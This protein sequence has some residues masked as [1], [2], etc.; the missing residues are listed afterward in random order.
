MEKVELLL[1]YHIL[2]EF[3]LVVLETNFKVDLC[4]FSRK[5]SITIL[6]FL[7]IK[8]QPPPLHLRK[9]QDSIL[10]TIH[11][12][13]NLKLAILDSFPI[14]ISSKRRDVQ[15]IRKLPLNFNESMLSYN[16]LITDHTDIAKTLFSEM[17]Y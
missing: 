17:S 5:Q 15:D 4:W 14:G 16:D 7:K 3:F 12:L 8:E 13:P 11:F 9:L 2:S 6:D 10:L 1:T